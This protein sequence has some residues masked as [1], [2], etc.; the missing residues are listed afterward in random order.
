LFVPGAE[1]DNG[2]KYEICFER[3]TTPAIASRE[4]K[5]IAPV[6]SM[7]LLLDAPPVLKNKAVLPNATV[8][9]W[10]QSPLHC[11][12]S[13]LVQRLAKTAHRLITPDGGLATDD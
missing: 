13:I 4:D 3:L 5:K 2:A 11:Y 7:I 8:S 1:R 6:R 9:R 12:L 10:E